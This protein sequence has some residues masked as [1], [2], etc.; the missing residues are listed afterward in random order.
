VARALLE[1]DGFVVVAEA[2]DGTTALAEAERVD[3]D[4]VLLDVHLPDMDG[5]EVSRR[6]AKL[7]RPPAVV[8]T[9]SRPI[10]DLRS[11]VQASPAAG[12]VSKDRLSGAALTILAG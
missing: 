2:P 3:P 4:L 5:F 10:A 1:R 6:L 8:L 11:R 12:F 7:R 9:S